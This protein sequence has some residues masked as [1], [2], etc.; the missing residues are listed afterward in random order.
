MIKNLWRLL[1]FWKPHWLAVLMAYVTLFAATGLQLYLPD[2]LRHAIDDGIGANDVAVL[3]RS[4]L[5]ILAI[6]ALRSVFAYFKSYLGE[7]LSQHVAYD[8]RNDL[9]S[10]I[11]SLSFSFHDKSQTG[12]LMSR[13]TADVETSRS[14][15]QQQ[16][17]APVFDLRPIRHRLDHHAQR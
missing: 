2:V 15:P 8:L 16:P 10:R 14:V 7:Y 11:Q 1:T 3:R 12:Q 9:Y 5:L 13:V 17:P 6:Y 4:A